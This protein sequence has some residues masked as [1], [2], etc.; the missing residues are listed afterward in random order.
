MYIYC[1]LSFLICEIGV[2]TPWNSSEV[3]FLWPSGIH[4]LFTYLHLCPT[5]LIIYCIK[6]E[7]NSEIQCN[8]NLVRKYHFP[9]LCIWLIFMARFFKHQSSSRTHSRR[10]QVW[11]IR[12][13]NN[14]KTETKISFL[15]DLREKSCQKLRNHISYA[16][17]VE[18]PYVLYLI[19]AEK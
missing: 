1:K 10:T 5:S 11:L 14:Y 17:S 9:L 2:I 15:E 7:N 3:S 13:T 19:Q 18:I 12:M 6:H 8:G 4:Y 16:W